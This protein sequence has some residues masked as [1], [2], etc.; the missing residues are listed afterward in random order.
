MSTKNPVRPKVK[1]AG[2][3]TVGA[4]VLVYVLRQLGAPVEDTPSEVIV[5]AAGALV[6]GAAWLKRDGLRGAWEQVLDG[7][8]G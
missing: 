8:R 7:D 1:A 2:Q 6:T 5:A 4:T 3:T